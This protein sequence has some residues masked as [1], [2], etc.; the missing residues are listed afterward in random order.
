MASAARWLTF[1]VST[2]GAQAFLLTAGDLATPAGET[3]HGDWTFSWNQL[4]GQMQFP[5]IAPLEPAPLVSEAISS[6]MTVTLEKAYADVFRMVFVVSIKSPQAGLVI[7]NATLKD[8]SGAELNTGLGISSQPDDPPG[9]FTVEL[10]PITEFTA[11]Q[12]KG[13]LTLGIGTQFGSTALHRRKHTFD[14]DLPV[15]PAVV[16]DPMQ[17]VT[18]NGVDMLLQR[19]KVTPSF[20]KAYLCFQKPSQADW[21]IGSSSTLQIG[22]DTGTLYYS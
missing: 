5:G 1:P 22:E 3:L 6:D 20:T 18:A 7:S 13:Q 14:V 11:G 21:E 2:T 19:V 15:Y 10:D 16:F 4:P 9:R 8:A 17:T 12:F